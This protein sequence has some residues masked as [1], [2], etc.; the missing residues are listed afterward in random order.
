MRSRLADREKGKRTGR[1]GTLP[2]EAALL[3]ETRLDTASWLTFALVLLAW[4]GGLFWLAGRLKSPPPVAS[5]VLFGADA[6]GAPMSTVR[7]ATPLAPSLA[8]KLDL[9]P[10]DAASSGVATLLIKRRVRLKILRRR[11]SGRVDPPPA[12]PTA[13]QRLPGARGGAR[14]TS[15]C[16]GGR[17]S[18]ALSL[19]PRPGTSPTRHAPPAAAARRCGGRRGGTDPCQL[20]LMSGSSLLGGGGEVHRDC[21]TQRTTEQ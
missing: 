7:P 19:A 20:T 5:T 1:I 8:L 11:I 21:L 2:A 16:C 4:L 14:L 18:P 6:L 12:A 15:R 3:M 9:V 10:T 17:L 13:A